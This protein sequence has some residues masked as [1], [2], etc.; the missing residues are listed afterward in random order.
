MTNTKTIKIPISVEISEAIEKAY[1]TPNQ[2]RELRVPLISQVKVICKNATK[3][4][5]GRKIP[6]NVDK[7]TNLTRQTVSEEFPLSEFDLDSYIKY[8]VENPE[9][10]PKELAAEKEVKYF[11]LKVRGETYDQLKLGARVLCARIDKFNESIKIT[12]EETTKLNDDQKE[13]FEIAR[14]LKESQLFVCFE[15]FLFEQLSGPLSETVL[16]KIEADIDAGF[17]DIYPETK[18]VKPTPPA[19]SR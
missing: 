6:C 1:T 17:N 7:V 4:I 14:K 2:Q 13:K 18:E 10:L 9:W 8:T 16:A 5:F 19:G 11:E 12:P 15:E 3:M